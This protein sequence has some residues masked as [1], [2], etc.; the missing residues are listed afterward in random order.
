[1]LFIYA[2]IDVNATR[3]RRSN[4]FAEGFSGV[5]AAFQRRV[6]LDAS[7]IVGD[8]PLMLKGPHTTAVKTDARR[9]AK[10]WPM[11]YDGWHDGSISH[12]F[13]A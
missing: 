8:I 11:G 6:G 1:M 7:L 3:W 5:S 12:D 9:T 10:P 4:R 2:I 13:R